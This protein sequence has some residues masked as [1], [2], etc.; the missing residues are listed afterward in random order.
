MDPPSLQVLLIST[1]QNTRQWTIPGLKSYLCLCLEAA[2]H[3]TRG[4]NS[5]C[6]LESSLE[7]SDYQ[8]PLAGAKDDIVT[9]ATPRLRVFKGSE[10]TLAVMD[11][12]RPALEG[13]PCAMGQRHALKKAQDRVGVIWKSKYCPP[14]RQREISGPLTGKH[15]ARTSP[16]LRLSHG[17][18]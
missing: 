12:I 16:F 11:E 13:G 18:P 4:V 7:L 14:Q 15:P 6:S 5:L 17:W 1:P 10:S 2:G 3:G 8:G 9:D